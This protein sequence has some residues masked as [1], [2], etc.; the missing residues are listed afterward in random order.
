MQRLFTMLPNDTFKML[1]K[2][3]TGKKIIVYD[4]AYELL[5]IKNSYHNY[6]TAGR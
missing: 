4:L 3:L 5:A 6:Q 2:P 1:W